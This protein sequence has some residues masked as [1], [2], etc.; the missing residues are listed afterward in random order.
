MIVMLAH[1]GFLSETS[2]MLHIGQALRSL[3]HRV[4]FATHGGPYEFILH[5]AG[6]QPTA[7]APHADRERC[8]QLVTDLVQ[9]GR[10]GVRLMQADELR[11]SVK[12]ESQLFEALGAKAVVTG[13]QLSAYIS[14]RHAKLPLITSH[15]GAFVGPVFERGLAP[16]PTTMPIPGTEWLPRWLKK[17][18]SNSMPIKMKGPCTFLNEH[19]A[20]LGVEP[21]PSIAAMMM[22]DLT[23]LTELPQVLGLDANELTQWTPKNPLAFRR[24]SR[25][26]ITGPLFAKLDQPMPQPVMRFLDGSRPTV[27]VVLSSST[28]DF[29][30]QVVQRVRAAG[31]RV[32]VG[33][34]IHEWSEP[35]DPDVVVAGVLPSHLVMP[36]VNLVVGM[37]GQGTSQCAMASGTPFIGIPLHPEQ[38][39]NVDL[40]ARH[41]A[42]T[43]IAPRH[44]VTPR[45]TALVQA[46]LAEPRYKEGALKIQRWGQGWDGA[47]QAAVAITAYLNSKE[48][49]PMGGSSARKGV[50][51]HFA[52][53]QSRVTDDSTPYQASIGRARRL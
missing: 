34:T 41:G 14:A 25:V 1:C 21:V 2:R 49:L 46:L 52:A 13:F 15:G 24:N 37:G 20:Q 44:A 7:L 29:L 4:Q 39:L 53:D 30:R 35:H 28:R 50:V 40:V 43:A 9:M 51:S 10:P 27:F 6:E 22:G 45:M 23:L 12:A 26:A 47:Q 31:V 18:F 8:A 48:G 11:Q 17:R 3:G 32:I 42:G 19:A 38:E 33:A 36:C 16:V 5:D